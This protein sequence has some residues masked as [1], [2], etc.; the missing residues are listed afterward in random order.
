[1]AFRIEKIKF[2]NSHRGPGRVCPEAQKRSSYSIVP[3]FRHAERAEQSR[4]NC[5]ASVFGAHGA[6]ADERRRRMQGGGTSRE[7]VD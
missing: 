3:R 6:A 1:M 7:G 2:V 4:E 5:T